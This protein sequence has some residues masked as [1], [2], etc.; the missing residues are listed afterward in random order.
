MQVTDGG[1]RVQHVTIVG[2]GVMGL[3]VAWFLQQ[4]GVEVTVLDR[5]AVAAGSSWGN[6]GWISPALAAP[7]AE[8][9]ILGLGIRSILDPQTPL[10][11]PR[12]LRTL[13]L[14]PFATA[15]AR[16]CTWTSWARTMA[17]LAPLSRRAIDAYDEMLDGGVAVDVREGSI[18][19]VF[20]D[21][22]AAGGL[23]RELEGIHRAGVE[24]ATEAIEGAAL[25]DAFPHVTA[26]ARLAIRVLGQRFVD[27]GALTDA[28]AAAVRA[29]GGTIAS[30]S[31][32][33]AVELSQ[34]GVD[35]HLEGGE[36]IET[37]RAVL[38]TGA[39][40]PRLARGHGV[41]VRIAAGRG[42][43]FSVSTDQRL[44]APLYFPSQR[45]ACSPRGDRIRLAG[46]MELRPPDA[47]LDPARV[48]AMVTAARRVLPGVRWDLEDVWVGSRP[49]TSD[50]LP[51]AGPTRAP[52]IYAAGGH[53][54]HGVGLAPITGRLLAEEIVTG[55]TPAELLPLR[56]T[57]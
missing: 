39:W 22:S 52:R 24:V 51:V 11:V 35:V 1:R 7:L 47:P 12:Q 20:T 37:D 9:G 48:H 50:S 49:V 13:S 16:R 53:G 5:T 32:V 3:S 43:S 26:S 56:P 23:I 21:P 15:F 27:P 54:M 38:A 28:M 4:Q 45:L 10:F 31:N 36:L 18:T 17:A 6:A 2:A 44:D 25:R 30:G 41:R 14:L 33:T 29:R 40:L 34:R 42:Y 55:M 19:A 8:P 46:I 57:R